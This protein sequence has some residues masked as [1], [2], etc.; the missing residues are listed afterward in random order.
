MPL[1]F[2]YIASD[3]KR[4]VNLGLRRNRNALRS[5]PTSPY[6]NT[7]V[8]AAG[9]RRYGPQSIYCTQEY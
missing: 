5:F 8:G 6:A 3:L 7:L 9:K 2:L 4:P 1:P